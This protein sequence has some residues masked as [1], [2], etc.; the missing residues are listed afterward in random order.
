MMK[1][2]SVNLGQCSI[3]TKHSARLIEQIT[4]NKIIAHCAIEHRSF[5]CVATSNLD[6]NLFSS[7]AHNL[8][9]KPII[10]T[11]QRGDIRFNLNVCFKNQNSSGELHLKI[12]ILCRSNPILKHS[13]ARICYNHRLEVLS[14]FKLNGS[15][16][17]K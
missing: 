3:A 12:Y 10:K 7:S 15:Y 13:Y 1:I 17:Q 5:F 8:E 14:N 4:C 11:K 2:L 16:S 6:S 9:Q